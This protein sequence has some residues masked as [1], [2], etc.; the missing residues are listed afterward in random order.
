MDKIHYKELIEKYFEGNITDTEIKEV[1]RLDKERPSVAK[2]V[3][4]GVYQVGCRY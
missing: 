1:V 2:L 3:G 4:T